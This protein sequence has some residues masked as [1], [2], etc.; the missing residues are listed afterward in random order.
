MILLKL[1]QKRTQASLRTLK[2]K[3]AFM[4]K[5]SKKDSKFQIEQLKEKSTQKCG[6]FKRSLIKINKNLFD[7][8]S[9][10]SRS[11]ILRS[12]L[13]F[14]TELQTT[15]FFRVRVKIRI[16]VILN[17]RKEFNAHFWTKLGIRK[18]KR[19]LMSS[20]LRFNDNFNR[21]DGV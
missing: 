9:K 13:V 16:Q 6:F 3:V 10:R 15:I 20:L 18:W 1:T 5:S 14:N 11:D 7:N 12:C 2:T 17:R 8:F 21:K 4:T 19:L